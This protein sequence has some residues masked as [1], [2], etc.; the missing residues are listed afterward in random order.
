MNLLMGKKTL[1]LRERAEPLDIVET[2]KCRG[3]RPDVA[4]STVGEEQVYKVWPDKAKR[5]LSV[6]EPRSKY[7]AD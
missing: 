6:C 5:R 7:C 4:T 2:A 3:Q 1:Q